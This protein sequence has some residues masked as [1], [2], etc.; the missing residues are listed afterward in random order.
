MQ[1]TKA[2]LAFFKVLRPTFCTAFYGDSLSPLQLK[3]ELNSLIFLILHIANKTKTHYQSINQT[4]Q[5]FLIKVGLR[6]AHLNLS[7]LLLL[8]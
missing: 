1:S 3:I 8:R 2:Q 4:N 5:I 6:F 7:R